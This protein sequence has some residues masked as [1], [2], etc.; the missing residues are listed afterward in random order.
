MKPTIEQR[1]KMC[2]RPENQSPVMFQSWENL[3]FVH[4]EIDP[5]VIQKTLPDGLI[6]DTFEDRA[7]LGIVPFLMKN[8]R[9][10]WL[11]SV[12]YLSNFLECNVRTYV[13]DDE[14]N[15]GVWFYSLDTSRWLAS[16]IGR[17]FF[18]L[19]YYWAQMSVIKNETILYNVR[20]RKEGFKNVRYQYTT[21]VEGNLA[22]SGTLDFFL[23]ERYQLFTTDKSN[24]KLIS[25]RVHHS[26]YKLKNCSNKSWD[27]ELLKWNGFDCNFNKASHAC[28]ANRVDVEIFKPQKL[29]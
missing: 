26:P 9:P 18:S 6:V 20:R 28:V 10:R 25:C 24:R 8:I 1:E 22:K 21:D 19:P 4:W 13:H 14:G 17:V 15:P 29:R 27:S 5:K 12:P 2:L 23:L 7:Y 16:I 11:P 3:L